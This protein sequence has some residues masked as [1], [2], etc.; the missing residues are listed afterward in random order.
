MREKGRE[1]ERERGI[2]TN[3]KKILLEVVDLVD[4][5]NGIQRAVTRVQRESLDH[6]RSPLSLW[7][8]C[9]LANEQEL[10]THTHY[11]LKC[12]IKRVIGGLFPPLF[13]ATEKKREE[14]SREGS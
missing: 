2:H 10:T 5:Q 11:S 14:V 6:Q 3:P 4:T 8:L 12:P 13:I 9:V 7:A 1:R